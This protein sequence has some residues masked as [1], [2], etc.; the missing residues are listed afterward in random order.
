MSLDRKLSKDFRIPFPPW[1]R[2]YTVRGAVGIYDITN[3]LNPADVYDN[4]TS[5]YYGHF[6]G[7]QHRAFEPFLDLVY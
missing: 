6:A 4:V 2:K 5:P 7:P 3:H 1:V